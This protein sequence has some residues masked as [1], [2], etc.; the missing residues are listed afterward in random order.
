[1]K[2]LLI[3]AAAAAALITANPSALA[4]QPGGAPGGSAGSGKELEEVIITGTRRS[5]RT[6]TE[7]SAPIDVVSGNDLAIQPSGSMVDTLSSLVPSFIVGQ[8]SISYAVFCLKK[9]TLRGL[10]APEIIMMMA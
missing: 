8:N 10:P 4:Q 7:S 6:V 9:K 2:P 1:M 5:D 3:L